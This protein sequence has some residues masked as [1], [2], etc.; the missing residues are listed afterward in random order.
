MSRRSLISYI[1]AS[2]FIFFLDRITKYYA[3]ATCMR[4]CEINRFLS[5]EVVF[6]RGISWGLLH[7]PS[8]TIFLLVTLA[9]AAVTFFLAFYA[10]SRWANGLLIVGETLV[11]TGSVSNLIDR[12]L[13]QGVIDF[14]LFSYND[15][16]W[17]VF[18][19]ADAAIVIGIGIMII[20]ETYMTGEK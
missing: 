10:Y 6:N 7:S 20:Q 1:L 12:A 11:I 15:W 9:I 17:P 5:F 3:L 13:Y 18:N 4:S 14:I 16:S 2:G 19:I 8:D